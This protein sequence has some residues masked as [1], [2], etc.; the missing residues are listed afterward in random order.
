MIE[1]IEEAT[2]LKIPKDIAC[3]SFDVIYDPP[4]TTA[5]LLDKVSF[6]YPSYLFVKNS[7]LETETML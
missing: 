5:R 7:K 2:K 4:S 6:L 1:G 3:R